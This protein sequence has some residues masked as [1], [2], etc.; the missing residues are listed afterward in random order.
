VLIAFDLEL[1]TVILGVVNEVVDDQIEVV[2]GG[3]ATL[4]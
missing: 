3:N 1:T 4:A 2:F